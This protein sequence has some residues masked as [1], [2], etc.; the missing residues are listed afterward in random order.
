[1]ALKWCVAST[2]SRSEYLARDRMEAAG[3]EVL[4]P[5][6]RTPRPRPGHSDAPMFP[7]YLFVHCDLAEQG[8]SQLRLVPQLLGLVGFGGVLASVPDEVI[9]ELVQ[10]IDVVNGRGGLWL[11]FKPG[12]R[13]RVTLGPLESLAQVVEDAKSPEG[14]VRVLLDFLGGLT[15][16]RVPWSHVQPV[17]NH[18]VFRNEDGGSEHGHSPRRTRGGKRWIRGYGPRVVE[19]SLQRAG[20]IDN[21]RYSS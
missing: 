9:E 2:R 20:A 18:G 16:A 6:A 5:C 19:G 3:L 1:M 17:G 8:W 15:E 21:G 14:R 13:V 12:D 4:L 10:R 7:G 11:R